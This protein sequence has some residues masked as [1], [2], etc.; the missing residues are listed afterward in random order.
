ML[1]LEPSLLILWL[2]LTLKLINLVPD[3]CLKPAGQLNLLSL[4]E[5]PRL[6]HYFINFFW[7][8]MPEKGKWESGGI[9]MIRVNFIVNSCTY[10]I[11]NFPTDF[12]KS[13]C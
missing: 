8:E 12:P 1:K 5:A 10:L 11:L 2:I 6:F 4:R 3:K 13:F 9:I 7:E